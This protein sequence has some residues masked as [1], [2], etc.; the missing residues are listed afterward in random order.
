MHAAHRERSSA[1]RAGERCAFD[2]EQNGKRHI[3]ITTY[4]VQK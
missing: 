3:R 2:K 4:V 1:L